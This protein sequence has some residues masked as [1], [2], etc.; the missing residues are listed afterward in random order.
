MAVHHLYDHFT[1]TF[2]CTHHICCAHSLVRAD[3]Q[4]TFCGK[5]VR[6]FRNVER[7][8]HIV[9]NRLIGAILHERNMLMCCCVKYQLRMICFKHLHHPLP[10]A[11]RTDEYLEIQRRVFFPEF[12]LNAICIVF[13][14]IESNKRLRCMWGNLPAKFASDAP[15]SPRDQN[16]AASNITDD[17]A[18]IN[19]YRIT[20]KQILNLNITDFFNAYLAV[21][22]L[23][24]TR[25]RLKP[26]SGF[27]TFREQFFPLLMGCG[28]DRK[29]DFV[30]VIFLR[31]F[32]YAGLSTNDFYPLQIPPLLRC[33]VVNQAHYPVFR[34]AASRKFPQSQCR[35][36]PCPY[37]HRAFSCTII[38]YLPPSAQQTV[39]KSYSGNKNHE[40]NAI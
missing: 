34:I 31:R 40:K 4:H 10:V 33:I 29:N 8:K 11:H 36:P 39:G 9:F 21:C 14:N 22:Q 16:H 2:W 25:Q 24:N 3:E 37:E 26:A 13:K 20:P 15:A 12:L 7:S 28:W 5:P 30:N 1:N 38:F 19:F 35:S 18:E 17:V 27:L 6:C 32:Y 23:A